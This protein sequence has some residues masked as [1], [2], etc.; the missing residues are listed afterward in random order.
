M[1]ATLYATFSIFGV[2][3]GSLFNLLGTK[4]LMSFGALTYAFYAISVYLWGQV[5]DSYAPMAVAAAAILG[6]GAACLWGA[7]GKLISWLAFA[8]EQIF[9]SYESRLQ[10]VP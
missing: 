4:I 3:S 7:Q 5:D 9:Y 2:L 8:L 1:N 10:Q 6:I